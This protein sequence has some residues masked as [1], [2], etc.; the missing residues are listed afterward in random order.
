MRFGLSAERRQTLIVTEPSFQAFG[1]SHVFVMLIMAG[2]LLLGLTVSRNGTRPRADMAIRGSLATLLILNFI[3]YGV[4]QCLRGTLRWQEALPFQ[5]CDWTMIVVTI[6]LLN[7]GRQHWLEPAYFWGIGG[8]LQAVIT[9]NLQFDFP[10]LRFLSFFIDHGGIV[11][12]VVYLMI[13]RRFRPAFASVWWTLLWSEIYFAVTLLVDRIT[14]VNYG[15]LLHKPEA[16][17][18]LSLLSDS[19]PLY[20]LQMQGVAIVFFLLLYLPFAI[21][22]LMGSKKVEKQEPGN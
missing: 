10:D 4:R 8:S 1:L 19:R 5:L 21:A 16:A 11:L 20:L 9:P 7:G 3:G 13:T 22:D 18:L 17:S 12:G 6:A 14:G 15:F 2:S